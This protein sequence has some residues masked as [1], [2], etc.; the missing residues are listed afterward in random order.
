MV[1]LVLSP[2]TYETKKG[3]FREGLCS[4][5]LCSI[6][7]GETISCLHRSVPTLHKILSE[8]KRPL[9]MVGAGSGIAPF[10]PI[11]QT[12]AANAKSFGDLY[13]FYGCKEK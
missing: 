1:D 2:N 6:Q 9:I 7:L 13:L 5:F 12:K 4:R 3:T 10:R 11:W 8:P